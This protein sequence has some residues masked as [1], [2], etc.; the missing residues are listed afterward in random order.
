MAYTYADA[1]R[2]AS[3]GSSRAIE[4]QEKMII[5]NEAQNLISRSADW[6]WTIGNLTP[7]WLQPY[8]QDYGSPIVAIPDDF[9]RFQKIFLR[10]LT[11]PMPVT[12]EI[13]PVLELNM[14]NTIGSP[15]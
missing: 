8:V 11:E 5:L 3:V 6:R 12:M 9:Q 2:A 14:E 7:F 1:Y 13:H 15:S 10:R 4:E